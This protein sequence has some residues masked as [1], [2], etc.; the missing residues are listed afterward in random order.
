MPERI[1]AKRI[2]EF[3]AGLEELGGSAG[4]GRLRDKLGWDEEFYWRVQGKLVEENKIVPGR[5]KG[6]SVRV[7]A[8]EPEPEQEDGGEIEQVV[9]RRIV[10]RPLY[11]PI[12]NTMESKWLNRFGF[13]EF[14][15][16]STHSQGSKRT[17]G[18]FTRPDITV[19]GVRRYEFLSK[20]IE[21][22]TFE[23]KPAESVGIMGVLEAVA[24]REAAHLS[25]VLFAT[26]R[27][28]FDASAEAD[29]IN[30]LAQKFGVG[31]ILA[32]NPAEVSTW[33]V[34]IDAIRHEPDPARLDR[35][36]GDLPDSSKK[37]IHK[38]TT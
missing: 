26:S 27:A 1:T 5:G 12:K 20:R 35:F 2:V 15:V 3:V 21:V 32:E 9:R 31:L 11:E 18:T 34:L 16:E 6:G 7:S 28:S 33:E 22:V 36:M 29:R 17:G 25:Y 23:I 4:N 38:L 10:E 19:V 8:V 30:E 13:H 14:L 24:H 37:H